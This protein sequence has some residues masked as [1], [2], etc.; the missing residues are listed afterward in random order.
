M[1]YALPKEL[2][3]RFS[4]SGKTVYNYL[5]KYPD[6]IRSKKE[7]GKT[8]V[9]LEDFTKVLQAASHYHQISSSLEPKTQ[10]IT[11]N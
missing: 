9:H 3:E 8:F 4:I 2:A 5:K 1:P 7:F 10:R 11:G 6:K